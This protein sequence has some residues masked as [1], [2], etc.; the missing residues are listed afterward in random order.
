MLGTTEEQETEDEKATE[1]AIRESNLRAEV[2]GLY[3]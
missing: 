1:T 2:S 3:D